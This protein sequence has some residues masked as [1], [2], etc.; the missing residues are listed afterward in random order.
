MFTVA[1][2][3]ENH[4]NSFLFDCCQVVLFLC[5]CV[6]TSMKY[7]DTPQRSPSLYWQNMNILDTELL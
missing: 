6:I 4:R 3:A 5:H 2:V 7:S 1:V